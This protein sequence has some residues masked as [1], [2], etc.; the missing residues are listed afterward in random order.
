MLKLT[1]NELA[2]AKSLTGDMKKE[3]IALDEKNHLIDSELDFGPM[4]E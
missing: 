1:E 4:M 2:T 3:V